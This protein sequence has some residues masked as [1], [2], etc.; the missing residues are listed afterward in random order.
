MLGALNA[1]EMVAVPR[2]DSSTPV[3]ERRMSAAALAKLINPVAQ[4][5]TVDVSAILKENP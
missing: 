1:M 3:K 4:K 5:P 2:N